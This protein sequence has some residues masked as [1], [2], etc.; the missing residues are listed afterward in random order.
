MTVFVTD[1]KK[2][3]AEKLATCAL[4]ACHHQ[5]AIIVRRRDLAPP[6]LYLCQ[7]AAVA[8]SKLSLKGSLGR[9]FKKQRKMLEI[10]DGQSE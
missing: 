3:S 5:S 7:P 2:N 10:T 4:R 8:L 9:K 6:Q 1:K